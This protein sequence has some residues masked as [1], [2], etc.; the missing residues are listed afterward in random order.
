MPS[1]LPNLKL[2]NFT[3]T[4]ESKQVDGIIRHVVEAQNQ[5]YTVDEVKFNIE[6]GQRDADRIRNVEGKPKKKVGVFPDER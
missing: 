5:G 2:E 1:G 3:L 4:I 6:Y